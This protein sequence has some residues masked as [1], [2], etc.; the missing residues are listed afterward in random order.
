MLMCDRTLGGLP[1]VSVS[2]GIERLT[3]Y[4]AS[5]VLGWNCRLLQGPATEPDV[6]K[7]LK[8]A[9]RKAEAVEVSLT[10]YRKDGMPFTNLLSLSRPLRVRP[11]GGADDA[12]AAPELIAAVL[13]TPSPPLQAARLRG[14]RGR[15][16]TRKTPRG[17]SSR[18]FTGYLTRRTPR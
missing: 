7:A 1:I 10:N 6:V 17:R 15:Y 5:E 14:L 4:E 2:T 9:I 3:G 12:T 13:R 8:H 11:R 16:L 18:A